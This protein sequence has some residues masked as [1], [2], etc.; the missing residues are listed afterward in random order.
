MSR[1]PFADE[2]LLFQP[3]EPLNSALAVVF[4]FPNQYS[5]GITSL[6]YQVVWKT[7]AQRSDVAV[8]RLFTDYQEPLPSSPDLLG[9]SLSWELD[10]GNLLDLL[11]RLQIPLYARDRDSHHPIVFGGGPVLTANPEPF[12][13]FF[14]VVLLGDGE[15]LVDA[16]IDQMVELR[17]ADRGDQLRHL[18]QVPGVYVPSLYQVT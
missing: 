3:A 8:S 10:Y 6:G 12:A 7:L 16:F 17:T 2:T 5:V 15:T 9:F 18:A 13:D 4:A 14:D 1:F 11:D